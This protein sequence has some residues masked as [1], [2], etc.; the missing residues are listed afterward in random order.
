MRLLYTDVLAAA[1][2][3][4]SEQTLASLGRIY[5]H[6]L[7]S[8]QKSYAILTSWRSDLAEPV[9]LENV[10]RLKQMIRSAQLGFSKLLGKW[11]NDKDE[12][13]SEPSFFIPGISLEL[14]KK[15]Q[16]KFNQDA[17]VYAGPETEGKVFLYSRDG[18]T[19]DLGKFH[20][21]R[22]G[23][24]F[25]EIKGKSFTFAGVAMG[26]M[27]ALSGKTLIDDAK[28]KKTQAK[29]KELDNFFR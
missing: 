6:Y 3:G 28:L 5:Q 27:D 9:N 8:G 29:L 15:I 21:T 20:P 24:I 14:A 25:S 4:S 2:M 16:E 18:S 19:M 13:V 11:K 10:E 1:R 17:I 26:F 23:D 7:A 12:I 22:I